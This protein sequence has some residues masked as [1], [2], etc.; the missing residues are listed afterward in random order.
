MISVNVSNVL[1]NLLIEV[2]AANILR[3]GISLSFLGFALS[4]WHS[5]QKERFPCRRHGW[6]GWLDLKNGDYLDLEK[7]GYLV[8]EGVHSMD[9]GNC[10]VQLHHL[11]CVVADPRC[12]VDYRR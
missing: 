12:S 8:C 11:P 6:F 9:I 1:V 3:P 10:H 4:Y 7:A 2:S 5:I